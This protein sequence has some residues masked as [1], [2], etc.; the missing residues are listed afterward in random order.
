MGAV[1]A[2]L[3]I[4]SGRPEGLDRAAAM[5]EFDGLFAD[6]LGAEGALAVVAGGT[7]RDGLLLFFLSAGGQKGHYQT[8]GAQ[9]DSQGKP[10]TAA[11]PLGVG[12]EGR[13]HAEEQPDYQ[14]LHERC[15]LSPLFAHL[16]SKWPL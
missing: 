4:R 10:A 13:S 16:N 2:P 15:F 8:E 9:E 1:R 7:I 6:G 14:D 11:A 12:D 3:G 5:F